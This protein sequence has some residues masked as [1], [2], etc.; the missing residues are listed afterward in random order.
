MTE[1]VFRLI[2]ATQNYPWGKKGS[3]SLAAQLAD[4][5]GIPDFK[6][7][8]SKPYAEIWM[9]THPNAP[10]RVHSTRQLLSEHLAAHP[11]L[12]GEP[13]IKRFGLENG[14]I[15]F[16]FKV[17]SFD[18]ALP[19]QIHLDKHNAEH[20]NSENPRVYVDSNHKSGMA[21]ALSDFSAL[22]GFLPTSQVSKFLSFVPEFAS[23]FPAD[24]IEHF[25]SVARSPDKSECKAA[26]KDLFSCYAQVDKEEADRYQAGKESDEEKI[27]KSLVL[28]LHEMYPNDSGVFCAFILNYFDLK[29]GHA[30]SVATGEPHAY[31]TGDIIECIATSD[32]TIPLAFSPPSNLDIST[33]LSNVAYNPTSGKTL[34]QPTMFTRGS[35]HTSGSLLYNPPIDELA[36]MQV[37][38]AKG[39]VE[40]HHKLRGPSI[41]IVVEGEGTVVWAEGAKRLGVGKG[42]VVFIA[43]G[44]EVKFSALETAL[45]LYRAFV[46][47]A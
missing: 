8:E 1:Q 20:I 28:R 44:T 10:T 4:G 46:E 12:V 17:L 34:I 2:P 41:A 36:V 18:Q 5:A 22:C 11:R 25:T 33:F 39:G 35:T 6:I 43:A 13:S 21:L 14:Q 42:Q 26:L 23:L 31:I 9:G 24:I 32:N 45:K 15:P 38:V 19:V 37:I 30:F 3:N 40:S 47:V 16:L 29:P 27:V 7:D